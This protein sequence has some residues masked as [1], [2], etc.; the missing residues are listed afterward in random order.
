MN[1]WRVDTLS[2]VPTR[3]DESCKMPKAKTRSS[4]PRRVGE[5]P[6]FECTAQLPQGGGALGS[7]QGGVYQAL[8]EA[9]LVPDGVAGISIGA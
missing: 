7:D 4:K 2:S 1:S 5:H 6:T 8:A 3:Q 9:D